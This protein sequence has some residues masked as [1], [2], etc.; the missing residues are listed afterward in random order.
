MNNYLQLLAVFHAWYV[1]F[2]MPDS[3]NKESSEGYL[4]RTVEERR[5][6][7]PLLGRAEHVGGQLELHDICQ[8]IV[9]VPT[10]MRNGFQGMTVERIDYDLYL[11]WL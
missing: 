9:K 10:S 4:L 6:A 8:V 11:C 7:T 2:T 5:C 1:V 3:I